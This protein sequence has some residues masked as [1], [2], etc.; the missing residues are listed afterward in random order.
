MRITLLTASLLLAL[1]LA[2]VATADDLAKMDVEKLIDGLAEIDTPAPGL[3][4]TASVRGF[5][6]EDKPLAFGGGVIGSQAPKTSPHMREL[7]RRGV[8]VLP[9]LIEHLGDKRPTKLR[10]GDDFFLFRYFSDECDPRTL[11][12][13]KPAKRI[14]P[15]EKEFRGGYTVRIGDA[16][17]SIIGQIVNRRYAAIRYQ[18]TAGLVVNSPIEAPTLIDRVKKHWGKL[19]AD[20]HKAALITD[21]EDVNDDWWYAQPAL[22]RLRFYYP[23][24]YQRLKAGKLKVRIAELEAEEKEAEEKAKR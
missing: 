9:E 11:R 18:P 24:D 5:L 20:A 2:T 17:F 15:L 8:V 19:D 12:T 1:A 10:V 4:G 6:A 13:E 7:V 23:A 22:V 21:A 3:H 16:C 14:E